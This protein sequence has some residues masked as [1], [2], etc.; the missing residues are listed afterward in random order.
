MVGKVHDEVVRILATPEMQE[1]FQTTLGGDAVG[2]TPQQFAADIKN[3]IARWAKIVK[4]SGI[5]IE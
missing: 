1:R 5:K 4:G 3:D 2:N